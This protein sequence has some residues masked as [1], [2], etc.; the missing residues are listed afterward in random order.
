MTKNCSKCLQNSYT[1]LDKND[2]TN[3]NHIYVKKSM[4]NYRNLVEKNIIKSF[5]INTL[6]NYYYK[7][8][9]FLMMYGTVCQNILNTYE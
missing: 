1:Y 5:L 6:R 7:C 8:F 9:Y 3:A 4:L 2:A